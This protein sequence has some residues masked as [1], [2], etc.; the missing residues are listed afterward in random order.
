MAKI[1]YG[2][3]LCRD[4]LKNWFTGRNVLYNYRPSW[5]KNPQTGRNLELDI[6]Y[7]DLKIAVE[8]NG[9]QHRLLLQKRKDYWKQKKCESLGILMI[10]VYHPMDLYKC[11]SLVRRHTGIKPVSA[12]KDMS[13]F[14]KM[15]S[16]IPGERSGGWYDKIKEI[17]DIETEKR[18]E[19]RKLRRSERLRARRKEKRIAR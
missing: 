11:K 7:P 1:S 3:Q 19:E 18:D 15:Q 16:Y 9:V 12:K 14:L 17:S 8:F 6:F 10:S 4:V 13:L 2:E 5:L